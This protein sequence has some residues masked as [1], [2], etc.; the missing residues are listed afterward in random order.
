ML[1]HT[2]CNSFSPL[3]ELECQVRL[4]SEAINKKNSISGALIQLY[5]I[6]IPRSVLSGH[7]LHCWLNV[8][9]T[10]SC[11]AIINLVKVG[12]IASV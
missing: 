2:F 8:N 5:P 11:C 3:T 1:Y 10:M 12:I 4:C 9:C 7:K 6:Y